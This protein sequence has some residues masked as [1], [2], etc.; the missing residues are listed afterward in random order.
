MREALAPLRN[1]GSHL[2]TN[3]IPSWREFSELKSIRNQRGYHSNRQ[4]LHRNCQLRETL[5]VPS[6]S[7]ETRD[8][9]SSCLWFAHHS[10]DV[11][12]AMQETRGAEG[13]RRPDRPMPCRSTASNCPRH[14]TRNSLVGQT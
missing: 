4:W 7:I 9:M 3:L 11:N 10:F 8:G 2:Q 14:D 5:V 13:V 1:H 6:K 12:T